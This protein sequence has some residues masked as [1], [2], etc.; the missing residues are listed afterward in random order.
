MP[1]KQTLN[2]EKVRACLDTICPIQ[3]VDFGTTKCPFRDTFAVGM[4]ARGA[5]PY[6]VA[7]LLGDTIECREALCR[8]REGTAR[9]GPAH[10]GK[11][12]RRLGGILQAG[13]ACQQCS[14][15]E[16]NASQNIF[17]RLVCQSRLGKQQS[18]YLIESFVYC[19]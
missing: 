1:A 13:A 4:L 2:L 9:A 6:D 16:R 19:L 15:L 12:R 17:V 3:R 11:R 10:D 5:S 7:K 8:V 14:Q 18:V